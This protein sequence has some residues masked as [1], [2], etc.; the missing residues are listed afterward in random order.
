MFYGPLRCQS[1]E[2]PGLR[3]AANPGR[4]SDEIIRQPFSTSLPPSSIDYDLPKC[5]PKDPQRDL[6]PHDDIPT[7]SLYGDMFRQSLVPS[8]HETGY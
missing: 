1:A 4:T 5:N 7:V 3:S 2:A 6:S 8:P